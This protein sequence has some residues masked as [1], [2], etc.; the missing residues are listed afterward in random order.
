MNA[1][2]EKR[3][4]VLQ[5]LA[6]MIEPIRQEKGC[7]NCQGFQDIEDENVFSLIGE[8]ENHEDLELHI[9]SDRFRV[10]LG[11]NILL[12]KNQE[13]QIHTVSFTERS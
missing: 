9:R 12:K 8:W 2:P 7:Q 10:L 4:E 5:T 6:S 11:S 1:L 3:R 13:I